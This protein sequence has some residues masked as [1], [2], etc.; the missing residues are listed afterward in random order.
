MKLSRL[1]RC[2][3]APVLAL[4]VLCVCAGCTDPGNKA[5]VIREDGKL[6]FTRKDGTVLVSI[7]IE[8][9]ETPETRARGLMER[10][11]LDDTAGM[12]F[13]YGTTGDRTFWMRNTPTSLDIIFV[14]EDKRVVNIAKHTQPMSDTNYRSKGPAR[15][16][17]EVRAGFADRH[18]IK[19]GTQVRWDRFSTRKDKA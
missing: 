17:V 14:S 5:E 6:E 13:I 8:I 4:G 1:N 15:Y 10:R 3:I 19:E 16:V 2:A 7:V 11:W 12:L 9:A 18:G